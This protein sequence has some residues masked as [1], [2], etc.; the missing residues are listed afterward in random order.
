VLRRNG[1]QKY[2]VKEGAPPV[3]GVGPGGIV[4]RDQVESYGGAK[5][6]HIHFDVLVGPFLEPVADEPEPAKPEPTKALK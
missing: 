4:T 5:P 1:V 3:A 6:G 2:R